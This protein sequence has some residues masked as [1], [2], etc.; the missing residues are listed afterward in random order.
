[1][2]LMAIDHVRV[3]AGVPAGGRTPDL[4]FTR[5]VTNFCAPGFVFFA[6]ASAYLWNTRRQDVS[7][8]SRHLLTRG[9]LLVAL[10]LFVMRFLWTFNADVMN[11]NVA[12]VIWAIGWSMVVLSALVWLP[13]N[14]VAALGVIVVFAHNLLDPHVRALSESLGSGAFGWFWQFLYFG[15]QVSLSSAGPRIDILYVIVPW[16]AVMAAGYGFGKLLTRPADERNKWCVRI[17]LIA[18]ALFIV[19]RTF[20]VYG[21]PRPWSPQQP[22]SF[23]NTNKY[24]ASLSF[25]LMTIGP[26]IALMPLFDRGRNAFMNALELFG[27]VPLFFYVAHIPLIHSAAI[28]VSLIRTGTI[29]PWL[30]G[31]FPVEPPPQPPGYM[32]SLPLLYLVWAICVAIL[33]WACRVWQQR[34][35]A[36][37]RYAAPASDPRALR[38]APE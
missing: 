3:Y 22:L 29:T 26:L 33:Y 8:L 38:V 25:L 19:L 24:P 37:T 13:V 16:V 6:G 34:S 10:E 28:V 30:F 17:G 14:V 1:M 5:W 32:W 20:N 7:A 36:T 4:F 27:R 23:I 12:N 35:S 18:I 11:Y 21:D 9:F 31:N 15:G 2:V